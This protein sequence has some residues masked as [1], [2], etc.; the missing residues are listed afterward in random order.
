MSP[1]GRARWSLP[2]LLLASLPAQARPPDTGHEGRPEIRWRRVV[3]DPR[4]VSEGIATADVDLDD[5]VDLMV[6]DFWYQAPDWKPHPI[7]PH[8]ECGD[9]RAGYSGCFAC[10]AAD[11]D[12]DGFPDQIVIGFPGAPA[13]WYRNPGRPD[14]A[15]TEHVIGPSACNESPL[16]VDLF[17]DGQRVLVMGTQPEGELCWF[18][19]GADPKAPWTRHALSTGKAPG[20][21]QFAHGLGCGDLDGDGRADVLVNAGFWSQPKDAATRTTPW[22]FVPCALGGPCA[23]MHVLDVDADGTADVVSSSAHGR[24]VWWHRQQ[25]GEGGKPQFSPHDVLTT[26][27]QTHALCTG[28][29]DGDGRPDL[30]TGKRFWAHGPDGDEEPAGTPLLVWIAIEPGSPPKFTPHVIDDASGVGTQ[31][32]VAD[33][34]GDG[35]LDVV[36][37][38]KKGVFLFLQER[39]KR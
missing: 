6:G 30:V 37:A 20:T 27:T 3:V 32:E 29:I 15:W 34:N 33:V 4:F 36:V 38:N 5:R 39:G 19:P 35:L 31:F 13:K 22:P 18:Q 25:Q 7:R 21:E 2:W 28:D 24:G 9:G 11:V 26:I 10:F 12:H 14:G 23:H 1:R 8:Q 16:F 17:G